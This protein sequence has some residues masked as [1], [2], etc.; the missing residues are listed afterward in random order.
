MMIVIAPVIWFR[1]FFWF[2]RDELHG[3]IHQGTGDDR[4]GVVVDRHCRREVLDQGRKGN[5]HV[6][7]RTS[8]AHK[9]HLCIRG[10]KRL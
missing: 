7:K 1:S 4:T 6:G 3:F 5:P 2:V 9:P 10:E 8:L